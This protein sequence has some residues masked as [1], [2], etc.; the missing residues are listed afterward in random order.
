MDRFW[1]SLKV[2][3]RLKTSDF[4]RFDVFVSRNVALSKNR[5]QGNHRKQL[6]KKKKNDSWISGSGETSAYGMIS[7]RLIAM[8][9]E[10]VE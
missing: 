1:A 3:R 8:H 2:K 4:A 7:F 9:I 5:T 10:Q 6:K